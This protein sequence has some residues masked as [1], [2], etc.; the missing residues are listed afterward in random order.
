MNNLDVMMC[1]RQGYDNASIMSGIHSGVQQTIKNINPKA[2]FVPCGNHTLN[3]AGVHAVG[4][5]QL[6]EKFFAVLE[7]L[8]AFFAASPYR[9]GVLLKHAPIT[10]KRAIDTRWSSHRAAV[11]ALHIGFDEIMDALEELCNP[12]ENLN[13]RGDAH[14]ILEAIQSFT[15]FSF[16]CFWKVILRESHDAQTYLQQKGLLLE[17]FSNKMKAFVHFLVEERDNLVKDSVKA[18]IKKCTELEIPIE[19]RRVCRRRRMPGEHAEDAGLS[20]VEEVRRCMFQAL[21]PF[22]REAETS[23][24][25]IHRLNDMFGFLNPHTLLQSKS[26]EVFSDAF[27]ITYDDKMDFSELAVEIDR[28]KRLVLS[29]ET[30][31]DRNATEFDVLQWLVKSCLLD[32]TPYL[33]L[34]L[35]LYLTIGVSIASCERSFSKLKMIKSYLRSTM[36]DNWLSALSIL[37]IE[38]DYVQQLDFEDI[39]ADFSST[40]ARKV[41]F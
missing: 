35:K 29:R 33:C 30:T 10:L 5:S 20:V 9:W 15:S 22:K 39:V 27:K 38:R 8:Y 14:G 26:H 32:S 34:Y 18:A 3:F 23:F 41:Q 6:S 13:T 40:K 2:Q 11:N 28:F 24:T 7:R 25:S 36:S 1:R 16:L 19:D 17:Q 21:D 12:S 31:F 37:S 4:S